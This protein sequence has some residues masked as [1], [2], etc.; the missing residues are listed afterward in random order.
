M[1]GSCYLLEFWDIPIDQTGVFNLVLDIA[2]TY[3]GEM[4]GGRLQNLPKEVIA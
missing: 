1:L 4:A 3:K 2:V